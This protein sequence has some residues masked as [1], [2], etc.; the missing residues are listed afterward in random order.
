MRMRTVVRCEMEYKVDGEVI[1]MVGSYK[2]LGC[3]VDEHLQELKVMVQGC[4][5]DEDSRGLAEQG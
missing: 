4:C 1:P 3:A 2:Y 5:W